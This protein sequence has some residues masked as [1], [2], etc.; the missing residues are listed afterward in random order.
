MKL[1]VIK[2]GIEYKQ[3]ELE[4]AELDKSI[5]DPIAATNKDVSVVNTDYKFNA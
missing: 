2:Q 1:E 3:D 5:F 4:N